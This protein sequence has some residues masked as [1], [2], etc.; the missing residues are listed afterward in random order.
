MQDMNRRVVWMPQPRQAAFLARWEYEALYG[1][2]AGGGKSDALL[3]EAL[4]QVDIPHYRGII[5]RKT[6]PQLSEL[7]DRSAEIYKPAF[8]RAKYNDNKHCW[9]FPSGA[10]LFFGNMQHAKDRTNYQG[11]RYD[12]IAF[13]EVTHFTWD[14]YSYLFSRNRPN[15]PGT[16]CYVRA[17]GNPG[18]IGHGWVKERF[19]TPVAPMHTI[20]N[21]VKIR[22]PDG[23]EETVKR[24]RIF[25]PS[26]VFDNQKLLENNPDYVANLAMLPES[27]RQALL[28]GSWD[29]FAG[30]VFTE[31][32]NDPDHY[33]DRVNTH[34]IR[35]FLVPP[36]WRIW[37]S[38]DWGYAKPFSVGW[39][40]V[41]FDRRM[42]RIREFYGTSGPPNVGCRWEPTRVANEIRQIEAQDPNLKGRKI[43]GVA[44]PS[45]FNAGGTESVGELMMRE[46]VYWDKGD[47]NRLNGKMQV[48]HRL[49]FD[50]DGIPM[51]YVFDT[52]KH[53]I[54]TIPA[55][56]YDQTKVEDVDTVGEDHIYDELRYVCMKNPIAPK[57]KQAPQLVVYDPLSRDEPKYDRYE[58]YR[59]Y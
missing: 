33:E 42:Y 37:R 16:R 34:V 36:D 48:H 44:D 59:R 43:F 19:I 40:A 55:L 26:R 57:P 46:R 22:F 27:E 18:G 13:D 38:F 15:G 9:T 1:G 7:I 21:E 25:V 12:F 58:F 17:A 41:D 32:R 51:L 39:Y 52:C 50:E 24:S 56:V 8:P 45:I 29:T 31:W 20:W 10:K 6:V 23:R 47:N 53:F 35:P 5:F 14:E 54:R 28:E 30:Q 49:A 11:K 4:R 2:A 3:A